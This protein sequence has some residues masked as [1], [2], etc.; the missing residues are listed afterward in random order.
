MPDLTLTALLEICLPSSD[1]ES[2]G[3]KLMDSFD[4]YLKN[5]QKFLE[6]LSQKIKCDVSRLCCTVY[7]ISPLEI[8]IIIKET[9][10]GLISWLIISAP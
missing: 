1:K 10:G 2:I 8:W 3:R 7:V 5:S 6:L 4:S 9:G